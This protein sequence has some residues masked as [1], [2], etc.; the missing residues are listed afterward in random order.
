MIYKTCESALEGDTSTGGDGM[1]GMVTKASITDKF[2]PSFEVAYLDIQ[3]KIAGLP[4][5]EILGGRVRK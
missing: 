3:G 4:V 1:A 5:S 2:F